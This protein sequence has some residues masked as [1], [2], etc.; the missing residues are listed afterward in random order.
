M[1]T[2]ITDKLPVD[3]I[4]ETITGTLQGPVAESVHRVGELVPDPDAVLD[5]VSDG[6][7]HGRRFGRRVVERLPGQGRRSN[8]KR[9]VVLSAILVIAGVTFAFWRSRRGGHPTGVDTRGDWPTDRS[10][11]RAVDRVV[12]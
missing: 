5:A 9:W 11:P 2:S 12:A 1:N 6:L 10:S 3:S 7:T 4:G 8:A